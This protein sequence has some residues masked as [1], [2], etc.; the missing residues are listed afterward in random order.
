MAGSES[1]LDGGYGWDG[2]WKFGQ[3]ME[4]PDHLVGMR[5]TGAWSRSGVSNWW[6]TGWQLFTAYGGETQHGSGSEGTLRV[7]LESDAIAS[8]WYLR[9]TKLGGGIMSMTL[10]LPTDNADVKA[11][12]FELQMNR[13]VWNRSVKNH[14]AYREISLSVPVDESGLGYLDTFNIFSPLSDTVAGTLGGIE[15]LAVEAVLIN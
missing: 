4:N 13:E 3:G 1:H 9:L 12:D 5:T 2:P 10:F 14:S 11:E 8:A 7:S 6:E 15:W